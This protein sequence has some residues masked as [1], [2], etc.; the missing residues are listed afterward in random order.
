MLLRG[1]PIRPSASQVTLPR[2]PGIAA[3]ALVASRELRRPF[4][5]PLARACR[6]PGRIVATTSRV[7][8][9]LQIFSVLISKVP[10]GWAIAGH[11]GRLN[12]TYPQ[13]QYE[14]DMDPA[15]EIT[16]IPNFRDVGKTVNDFLGRRYVSLRRI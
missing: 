3:Q 15:S 2:Y 8:F 7:H 6:E 12:I 10:H 5:P 14:S 16:S 9:S 11:A 1:R 13:L 4:P